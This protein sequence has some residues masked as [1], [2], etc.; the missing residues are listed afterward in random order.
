MMGFWE[1]IQGAILGAITVVMVY[2]MITMGTPCSVHYDMGSELAKC[3]KDLD[4]ANAKVTPQCAPVD[5]RC[6]STGIALGIMGCLICIGG[7]VAFHYFTGQSGKG[8]RRSY[9]R[10]TE[11][12][13][14]LKRRKGRKNV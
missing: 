8:K 4:F 3:Q 9:L 2:T 11:D 7:W 12:G 10:K 5:C 1:H 6:G 13:Y 14:S